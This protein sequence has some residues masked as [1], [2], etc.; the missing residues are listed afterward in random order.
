V[1]REEEGKAELPGYKV[2]DGR[3]EA[4]LPGVELI[5]PLNLL[6][7][8]VGLMVFPLSFDSFPFALLL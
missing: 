2:D 8:V 3:L 7:R 1:H 6:N 5:L 4:G